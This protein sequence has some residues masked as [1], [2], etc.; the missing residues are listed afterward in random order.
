MT[1]ARARENTHTHTHT[2][3]VGGLGLGSYQLI[4]LSTWW[5][6]PV[7]P[8]APS[9]AYAGGQSPHLKEPPVFMHLRLL[10]QPP[11]FVL[12][13]SKRA[14]WVHDSRPVND[15]G[16][17]PLLDPY[18]SFPTHITHTINHTARTCAAFC[19]VI[20]PSSCAVA[21]CDATHRRGTSALAVAATVA[22]HA[23]VHV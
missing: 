16:I 21:A 22:F 8:F 23:L 3:E 10:S 12:H 13:T 17:D 6:K 19:S 11:L 15:I 9:L 7:Q 5:H 2:R 18:I 1:H 20:G 4:G 14:I